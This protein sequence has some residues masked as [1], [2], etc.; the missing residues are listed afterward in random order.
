MPAHRRHIL[1][2]LLMV[3]WLTA[4]TRLAGAQ[5][6]R[7][8]HI[9][10]AEG[11]TQGS[12][13]YIY[14]DSRGF[15]WL[16]TQDGLNRYDGQ[17]FKTFRPDARFPKQVT[18]S[19]SKNHGRQSV[20]TS[21]GSILGV[22]IFGIVESPDGNLW[23]GTEEGLN[24]YDRLSSRFD[25]IQATAPNGNSLS[26]RTLPFYS[27][28]E[29][30]LYLSD[31]EGLVAINWHTLRKTILNPAL[32]PTREYDLQSST[33]RTASGDVWLHAPKGVLRY[34]LAERK[35]YAYF[36]DRPDNQVGD[37]QAIFS[38]L[39]DKD[40]KTAWLGTSNGLIRLDYTQCQVQTYHAFPNRPMSPV[41]SMDEDHSGGLW[42]GTQ[43]DGLLLFDK[44]A[45]LFRQFTRFTNNSRRL[46]DFEINKVFVDD[47]NVVWANVDPD[48]LAKIIPNAF[49]FGG[50]TKQSQ[51]D[52]VPAGQQ[53]TNYTVRSFMEETPRRIWVA[54]EGGI[55]VF[56]P[57][58]YQIVD[59][60]KLNAQRQNLPT[61]NP[62]KSLLRDDW[63]RIWVGSIG[64]VL[65]YSAASKHFTR[66]DFPDNYN[67]LVAA[68]YVRN[69]CSLDPAT[70]LAATEDGL[71]LLDVPTSSWSK[72]PVLSGKNIFSL[73]LDTRN[74]QLWVGTY[75]NGFMVYQLPAAGQTGPW[76]LLRLGLK[77]FT[78]LN[79][80]ND[81]TRHTTW[82]ATDRGLGAY[83]QQT[84]R[85]KLFTESSGLANAFI[86]G[87]L[88]DDHKCLWMS[89]NRGIARFDPGTETFTNFTLTDGLQGYEYNGNA[90][91]KTTDGKLYFGGVNGFNY[92]RPTHYRSSLFNPKVHIYDLKVNEEPYMTDHYVGEVP[93]IDLAYTDNTFSLEFAAIDYFSNGQ[94]VYQYQ[95]SGYDDWWVQAGTKNYV[96]YANIPPGDY[97]FMVRAANKD[98][99]WSGHIRQLH[100][101]VR[102]PFWLRAPFI[103]TMLVVIGTLIYSIFRRRVNDLRRQQ[104]ERLQL[105]YDIQEQVKKDIARDLHDEIGT[106]LA[107]LKLYASQLVQH[108]QQSPDVLG[109][110]TNMFGLINDTISDVRNLLRKLDPR[111]LEQY[112]YVAAVEELFGRINAVEA[113]QAHLTLNQAPETLPHRTALMLYRITQELLNNSLKHAAP[114]QID[115]LIKG[116]ENSILLEYQDDGTGFDYDLSQRG[117][118]IG[119]IEARVAMLHGKIIWITEP[120]KGTR[121]IIDI[122]TRD[123]QP[124]QGQNTMTTSSL[125]G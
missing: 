23:I 9:G 40:Q 91:L 52:M 87:T 8:D 4:L 32:R 66:I 60:F 53:L 85:I 51:N 15:L 104:A 100:I 112:G 70:L 117:L 89:T 79:M 64:G 109:I 97:T 34:N 102:P 45:Q 94:N 55:D 39:L 114:S 84:K 56:D 26:N 33:T 105:A 14:K 41:F 119:N 57:M 110:K 107:T 44:R 90:Y 31:L 54:N 27:D 49:L 92:F 22:N 124:T 95:L 75:L 28:Q 19:G 42:L 96:R 73:H 5:A 77:G 3:L 16:G 17:H 35:T 21:N 78:V 68:N 69:M 37:P 72:A 113:V 48:G 82:I 86:Y 62:V 116:Q 36:S 18:A 38:F 108:L 7:I 71:Y 81:T 83:N 20:Q 63:G 123:V 120:G 6:F 50:L 106:R 30:V 59:R 103:L 61:Y 2:Y 99:H 25:C 11:L 76:K 125:S 93:S 98:K 47:H 58:S 88:M 12:V 65:K 46:T 13:Y 121:V 122:P 74:R 10:V 67:S 43:S 80:L 101:H 115:L 1:R 29:D 111:T 118:G 24:R